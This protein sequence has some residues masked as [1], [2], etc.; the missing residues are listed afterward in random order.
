MGEENI[1]ISIKEFDHVQQFRSY[2]NAAL[3]KNLQQIQENLNKFELI[4]N[5]ITTNIS[6]IQ[7]NLKNTPVIKPEYEDKPTQRYDIYADVY[8]SNALCDFLDLPRKKLYL[9]NDIIIDVYNYIKNEK[10]V[11]FGGYFLVD[12]KLQKIFTQN[13]DYYAKRDKFLKITNIYNMLSKHF[14]KKN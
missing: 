9:K 3:E 7:E 6:N 13:G 5:E 14:T 11:H 8:V 4:K 12:L 10:L 2:K 1:K